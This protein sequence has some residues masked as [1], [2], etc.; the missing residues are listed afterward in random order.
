MLSEFDVFPLGA[1][2]NLLQQQTGMKLNEV[3][4]RR[5]RMHNS[6]SLIL[7]ISDHNS[8][9]HKLGSPLSFHCR[10]QISISL[11]GE[12]GH[13]VH[14]AVFRLTETVQR[15]LSWSLSLISART[16]KKPFAKNPL[17]GSFT[18]AAE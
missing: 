4:G 8:D 11:E 13:T 16:K 14:V 15:S 1:S 5:C 3:R 7:K 12:V 2:V 10:Y 9:G 17:V 6:V 18:L